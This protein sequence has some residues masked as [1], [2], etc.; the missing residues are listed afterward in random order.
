MPKEWYISFHGGDEKTSFN[1]IHVYSTNGKELRKALNKK[2][3]PES[4]TLRELRGFVFGPDQNLYVVNAYFEYSEVLKFKGASNRD[5][6]HDFLGIFVKRHADVN[7]G[8]DHPF[9]VAF[10]S[11]GDLYVSS[12]N[13]SLIA[14]Y[15]GPAS[16]TGQPGTPMP[17]PR[18]L[19]IEIDL[20]PGTFVPSA[21]HASNGLV[22]VREAIFAP[23]NNLYVAD[24][25]ADC[26][27]IYEARTGHFLRNL[28][29]ESDQVDKPIHL[30]LSPDGRYLF[31]G[32]G[33][34]DS[35]LRHDLRR[36]FTSVFVTPKSGGL[37]GPAGMAFGDDDFLYVA[38][39]NRKEILRYDAKDGRPS[40]RPFIKNLADNPEFLMLVG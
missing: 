29:S 22:E 6:E 24:R 3:I 39:R 14:R 25:A 20:P 27:R 35:I 31:I 28:A 1:N 40:S 37:N 2:S 26:V 11:E 38:S 7:P 5:G 34:T 30:L 13:T 18:A 19:D 12:Q 9:N 10:D 23:D 32:S 33:G 36:N 4:I 15:H 17:L 21:K 8:I 16:K